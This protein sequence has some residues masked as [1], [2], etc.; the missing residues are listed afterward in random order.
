[1][2]IAST[3][4]AHL[5]RNEPIFQWAFFIVFPK[6]ENLTLFVATAALPSVTWEVAES[7]YFFTT[8]KYASRFTMNEVSVTVKDYVDSATAAQMWAWWMSVGDARNGKLNS[9]GE[10]KQ[11][12]ELHSTDGRG[13]TVDQWMLEDCF[14]SSMEFGD[15]DYSGTDIVQMNCTLTVDMVYLV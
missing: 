10:Y 9:P 13:E 2:S 8:R 12:A 4:S 11:N 1:M 7:A 15:L 3:S 6:F 5:G 14:P